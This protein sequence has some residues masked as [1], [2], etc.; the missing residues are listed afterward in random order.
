MV[1]SA[2]AG[3]PGCST[4]IQPPQ[5]QAAHHQLSPT[6]RSPSRRPILVRAPSPG[7]HV[8]GPLLAQSAAPLLAQ[9]GRRH[10]IGSLQVPIGGCKFPPYA[11]TPT[12]QTPT[13]QA[14]VGS[15]GFNSGCNSSGHNSPLHTRPV[16]RANSPQVNSSPPVRVIR[17]SRSP[18]P[19]GISVSRNVSP[20][21][22][23]SSVE[24]SPAP[25]AQYRHVSPIGTHRN[26][27]V[28][29][30]NG[31]TIGTPPLHNNLREI[32]N[33]MPK[34]SPTQHASVLRYRRSASPGPAPDF[35]TLKRT[36][37][38]QSDTGSN[39]DALRTPTFSARRSLGGRIRTLR[40]DIQE[41]V[42][43][44]LHQSQ[45]RESRSGQPPPSCY[46]QVNNIPPKRHS[47]VHVS[48]LQGYN[49]SGKWPGAA[50]KSVTPPVT[51]V[52]DRTSSRSF[53]S[54]TPLGDTCNINS[55]ETAFKKLVLDHSVDLER[56][57]EETESEISRIK[58]A[59]REN[60]LALQATTSSS[61]RTSTKEDPGNCNHSSSSSTVATPIIRTRLEDGNDY[62]AVSVETGGSAPCSLQSSPGNARSRRSDNSKESEWPDCGSVSAK[63]D[64]GGGSVIA[65]NEAGE[66]LKL[67]FFEKSLTDDSQSLFLEDLIGKGSSLTNDS[68]LLE[69]LIG[70]GSLTDDSLLL[71]DLIGKGSDGGEECLGT[72]MCSDP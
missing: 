27:N 21:R 19:R 15:S 6:T 2:P 41:K 55:V 18:V 22:V 45:I 39:N 51:P 1:L 31:S 7:P 13:V 12:V 46:K 10:S 30:N 36:S 29:Q 44:Q 17:R 56:E 24:V 54:R 38:I 49:R 69:D 40:S 43:G 26:T 3:S 25:T 53:T 64:Y 35:S 52:V 66:K 16:S 71:K 62:D 5:A 32:I 63:S 47:D 8:A 61:S 70:K 20:T 65:V 23:G 48:A 9:S 11:A 37:S 50:Y 68:L 59:I 33:A 72:N 60:E 4:S 28:V 14:L 57:M 58:A 34:Q 42:R 67:D